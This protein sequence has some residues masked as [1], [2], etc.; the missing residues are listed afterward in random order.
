MQ[1]PLLALGSG[2]DSA[3]TSSTEDQE[4]DSV[5][6]PFESGSH[7]LKRTPRNFAWNLAAESDASDA[8]SSFGG[9]HEECSWPDCV[10]GQPE[11]REQIMLHGT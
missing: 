4:K 1:I 7:E 2:Q 3:E 8:E 9:G 6:S 10:Q 11:G 5:V